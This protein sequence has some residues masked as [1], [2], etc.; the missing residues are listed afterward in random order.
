[1][2]PLKFVTSTARMVQKVHYQWMKF[3]RSGLELALPTILVGSPYISGAGRTQFC[4]QLIQS[5]PVDP[6]KILVL[7]YDVN[8]GEMSDDA[9]LLQEVGADVIWTSNRSKTLNRIKDFSHWELIVCDGGWEDPGLNSAF[10]I[11]LFPSDFEDSPQQLWPQGPLRSLAN[12]RPGPQIRLQWVGSQEEARPL[13]LES[14]AR[15]KGI[16]TCEWISQDILNS[17]GQVLEGEAVLVLSSGGQDRLIQ[18]LRDRGLSLSKIVALRDHDLEVEARIIALLQHGHQILITA[19]E[20]VRCSPE[21]LNH[22]SLYFLEDQ[23]QTSLNWS[24]FW[25]YFLAPSKS[26]GPYLMNSKTGPT[27]VESMMS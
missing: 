15:V 14:L 11:G 25:E 7:C 16:E 6:S 21:T 10:R 4:R 3:S 18:S 1:M 17:S 27:S 2:V 13:A 5:A 26:V 23:L 12:E 20:R 9:L 24:E 22:P 19:K 8:R